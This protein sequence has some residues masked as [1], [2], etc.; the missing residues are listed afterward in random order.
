MN[1]QFKE[2]IVLFIF[3]IILK[4]LPCDISEI[5]SK[6]HYKAALMGARHVRIEISDFVM[7]TFVSTQVQYSV[8]DTPGI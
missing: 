2:N 1:Y 5:T 8:S 7:R 3:F 6:A 4:I